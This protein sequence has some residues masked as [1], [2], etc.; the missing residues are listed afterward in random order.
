MAK[1][2]DLHTQYV[3]LADTGLPGVFASG[4]ANP[5]DWL[6]EALTGSVRSESDIH[7]SADKALT[8]APWF[9]GIGIISG[10][11]ARVALDVFS[12]DE[13]DDR[14]KQRDHPA[15]ELLNRQANPVMT[16]FTFRETV[17]SYAL[18]WGNGY[19]AIIWQG[20]RPAALIPISPDV[21]WPEQLSDSRVVYVHR[22]PGNPDRIYSADDILHIRGLGSGLAGYSVYRCARESLGLGLAAQRHGS[23]HFSNDGRPSII[24]KTPVDMS[25][26]DRDMLLE[27]WESR[28]RQNPGRP[29]LLTGPL[30]AVPLSGSNEDSQWIESRKFSR[31]EVASWL[32]LPPH[33]LGSDARL[34][35]NSVEAEE[36][37]YVSQTLMRW[38]KRWEA[39]CDVKL[40][41][42]REKKAW[43]YFE[44]NTGALIEGDF[45][46]QSSVAV[47]LKNAKIIT[48]NEARKKFNLN[49]V[50]G[51]DE[52]EN[53]ATS[54]DG[55]PPETKPES[56]DATKE[57][58]AAHRELIL[59]RMS[60]L[61]R[62]EKTTLGKLI[63]GHLPLVAMQQFYGR[64][65]PKIEAAMDVCLRAYRTIAPCLV[66][67]VDIAERYCSD[68]QAAI[69]DVFATNPDEQIPAALAAMIDSWPSTRPRQVVDWI[70]GEKHEDTA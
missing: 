42:T 35:Y 6:W 34:S 5:D 46:T 49:S 53:A 29:A 56:T 31:D 13:G 8:I 68:S 50:E 32:S 22:I 59:D 1:Q 54:S 37:S 30:E 26:P 3:V 33:K 44:H 24:L 10:D 2:D 65:A 47:Q 20:S 27:Q 12:R 61:A 57:T 64:F 58:L 69:R 15:Y 45:A 40:L 63:R 66:T 18:S 14:E 70:D 43:W 52:F 48:R 21:M 23:R 17:T 39:E 51:G 36:R 11:M 67:P 7:V 41:S 19:A 62:T 38:F 9:Q 16:S 28:H 25:K 60:Q 4:Y 55:K